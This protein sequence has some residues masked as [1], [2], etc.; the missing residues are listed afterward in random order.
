MY[1]L[2]WDPA[3]GYIRSWSFP[4]GQDM[5]ENLQA[6]LDTAKESSDNVVVPDPDTW[7]LPYGYFAIGHGSGC[8]ASHFQNMHI[9][10]N[11]AFC[12]NVAGNRFIR[13]C[14]HIADEYKDMDDPIEMCNAFVQSNPEVIQ[15]KA[16]WEISGVY[17]YER[18]LV[19]EDTKSKNN[20]T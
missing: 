10:F 6:T 2:E 17:V 1:A 3:N 7:G 15:K 19:V 8:A 13:D 14:P 5:P 9:V 18:E 4:R 16:H 12:G 20:S 11:L